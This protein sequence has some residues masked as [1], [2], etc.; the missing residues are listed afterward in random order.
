MSLAA[1]LWAMVVLLGMLFTAAGAIYRHIYENAEAHRIAK[2][3]AVQSESLYDVTERNA[4]LTERHNEREKT[5]AELTE[6]LKRN[7]PAPDG[8]C[9][10]NCEIIWPP[11]F[12][13]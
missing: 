1:R 8:V 5:L 7:A 12:R 4:D 2:S 9:P 10:A 13:D 11:K 6:A 3:A